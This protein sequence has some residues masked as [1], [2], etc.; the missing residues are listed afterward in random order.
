MKR[1]ISGT[2]CLSVIG[3]SLETS[4]QVGA[5][6]SVG[7]VPVRPI[8]QQQLQ[9]HEHNPTLLFGILDD[10]MLDTGRRSSTDAAEDGSESSYNIDNPRFENLYHELIFA[11]DIPRQIIKDLDDCT[12]PEFM[13]YLHLRIQAT[14]DDEERQGL[15]ELLT[16]I[17]TTQ[18]TVRQEQEA[19]EQQRRNAVAL[20]REKSVLSHMQEGNLDT[21]TATSGAALSNADVIKRANQIDKAVA[22]AALSDDE[23]PSDFISDCRQVVNLSSGFNNQGQMRVGGQ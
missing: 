15:D 6:G 1:F 22:A 19:N 5:F 11:R 10:M 12:E 3:V 20:A 17:R 18:T 16:M 7:Y 21:T 4:Q 9:Q 13:N 23:K 2:T 14:D 8:H